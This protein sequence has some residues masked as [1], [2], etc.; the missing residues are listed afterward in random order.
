M[1]DEIASSLLDI[2]KRRGLKQVLKKKLLTPSLTGPGAY[3]MFHYVYF[4]T[5]LL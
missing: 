1:T 2:N 3:N 4:S 5:K